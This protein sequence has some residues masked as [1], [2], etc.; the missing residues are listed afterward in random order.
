MALSECKVRC[1]LVLRV[2]GLCN[3]MSTGSATTSLSGFRPDPCP[4]ATYKMAKDG[5]EWGNKS[6]CLC[7]I[8]SLA[9]WHL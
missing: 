5:W 2:Q 3:I 8:R 7:Q 4:C 1:R 9:W 6:K